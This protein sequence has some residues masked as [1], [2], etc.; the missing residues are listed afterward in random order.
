MHFHARTRTVAL[1]RLLHSLGPVKRRRGPL[2]R[3]AQ[4]DT[5]RAAYYDALVPH[6]R[7]ATAHIADGIRPEILRMLV[8]QRR[9]EGKMDAGERDAR[10]K[11][12]IERAGARA[13]GQLNPTALHAIAERFG[14]RTTDF[15]RDQLDKQVRAAIGVPY[16]AIEKPTRDLVP[17]FAR[18]N[19]E[20]I[21]T[22]PERYFDRMSEAVQDAFES[23]MH[24][25]T[26]AERFVELDG[27]AEDDALRIA[28]D[29]IGKLNAAVNQE[30]QESLGVTQYIWRGAN[31][32]RERDNH[33]ALEGETF[34]WDDPPLGGGTSEDEEGNPGEGI[35]CRCFAEPV[36]SDIAADVDA[37]N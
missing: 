12:L 10:A 32:Q 11:S 27:I 16:T 8:D 24:P 3:Q 4:P 25:E 35:Q 23:G 34:D 37:D 21:K 18:G 33:S 7:A 9:A 30:R 2:P 5:I 28:R 29:Q 17:M 14:K 36:L 20:L 26:L 22:V 13:A 31:D 6:V 19:V 1:V 15:Q